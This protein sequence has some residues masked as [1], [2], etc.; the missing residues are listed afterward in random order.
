MTSEHSANDGLSRKLLMAS[1]TVGVVC[2]VNVTVAPRIRAASQTAEQSRSAFDVISI[3]RNTSRGRG[4]LTQTL[5]GRFVATNATVK[6]LFRP[7]YGVQDYQ[8][9][10]GPAWV[11]TERYDIQATTPFAAS[12]EDVHRMLQTLLAEQFGVMLHREKKE[13]PVYAL[14]LGKNGLKLR[15][16]PRAMTRLVPRAATPSGVPCRHWRSTSHDCRTS[17]GRFW[18]EQ[19]SRDAMT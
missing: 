8:I 1:L 13:I 9:S 18:I 16:C 2:G 10:G 6:M 4:G 5:P 3:K 19:G 15:K 14:V 12:N 7:A 11:D 17:I